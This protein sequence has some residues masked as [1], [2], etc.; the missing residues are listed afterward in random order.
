MLAEGEAIAGL[1]PPPYALPV[2]QWD[3]DTTATGGLR[4]FFPRRVETMCAAHTALRKTLAKSAADI[5]V[6]SW[7]QFKW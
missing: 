3:L 5:K 4:L 1:L 2:L 7:G 6:M